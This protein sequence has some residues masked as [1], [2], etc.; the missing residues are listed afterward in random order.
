MKSLIEEDGFLFSICRD[1]IDSGWAIKAANGA[2]IKLLGIEKRDALPNDNP[3][4]ILEE[5]SH[6]NLSEDV[7]DSLQDDARNYSKDSMESG[8]IEG[9]TASE[10]AVNAERAEFSPLGRLLDLLEEDDGSAYGSA[11][12]STDSSVEIDDI[13]SKRVANAARKG[14][15][16]IEKTDLPATLSV[17]FDGEY[18]KVRVFTEEGT[19]R[20]VHVAESVTNELKDGGDLGFSVT[21]VAPAEN[22]VKLQGGDEKNGVKGH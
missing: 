15:Q 11:M 17:D 20:Q 7:S 12:N 14:F 6:E 4:G 22:S 2:I 21:E 18:S 19:S 8:D 10:D 9:I 13:V 1:I 3:I 16:I 5:K